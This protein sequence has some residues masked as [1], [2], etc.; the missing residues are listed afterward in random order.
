[1]V[2]IHVGEE[3]QVEMGQEELCVTGNEE[4]EVAANTAEYA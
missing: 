2:A 3:L 1:M 4:V